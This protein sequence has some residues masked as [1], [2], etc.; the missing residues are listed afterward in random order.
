MVLIR[1]LF[2]FLLGVAIILV[3]GGFLLPTTV[4]TQRDI[5]IQRSP[6]AVFEVLD[7]F[8]HFPEWSPWLRNRP[9]ME[10]TRSG[11][12][13]GAGARLEWS[14]GV[15]DAGDGRLTIL[16]SREAEQIDMELELQER[17]RSD[18]RFE[19]E[20]VAGGTRVTWAM[21]M[22]FGT[23]DLVGR[24]LGLMLPGLI[25]RDYQLGLEA[26]RDYMEQPG[27]VGG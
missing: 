10:Y 9:D 11:P 26:L 18:S 19:L 1:R 4:E 15:G 8:E 5:E 24:Y 13:R 7:G 12:D 14:D 6:G 16:D 27:E 20:P 23:F 2:L 21:S 22:E 17:Y 3:I 25:G